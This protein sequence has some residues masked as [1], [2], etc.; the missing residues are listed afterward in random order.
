MIGKL[1]VGAASSPSMKTNI[2][3][4][5]GQNADRQAFTALQKRQEASVCTTKQHCGP[6][7]STARGFASGRATTESADSRK[8][9]GTLK[10]VSERSEAKLQSQI[11]QLEKG[12]KETRREGALD[13]YYG[14]EETRQQFFGHFEILSK[15][16]AKSLPHWGRHSTSQTQ[17]IDSE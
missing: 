17:V 14:N 8:Q 10:S 9:L 16:A 15:L 2:L 3:F 7:T 5:V 6:S 13:R 11:A 12:L 4:G 1:R